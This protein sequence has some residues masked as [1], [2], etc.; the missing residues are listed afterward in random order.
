MIRAMIFDLDGTLVQTEK[1]KARSY[2]KAIVELCPYT[3]PEDEATEAFKEFVGLSRKEVA[4]GLIERYDLEE[5]AV[6][7]LDQMGVETTWQAFV[8]IRL[9]YYEEMMRDPNIIRDNQWSHNMDLLYIARQQNCKTALATMSQREQANRVLDILNIH[10][11]FDFIATRDDV[12][13][14][15]P[16]P[17]IY[18]LVSSELDIPPDET[19][20]IED[21]PSGV[22]AAIAAGMQVVAVSTP[23]TKAH[24]HQLDIL[25]ESHIVDEPETLLKVVREF[26]EI[27]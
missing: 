24:L 26:V 5:K 6:K 16:N 22:K 23:F 8:Q 18:Q 21:S 1:L 13:H 4:L 12:E 25:D 10:D 3:V 20:V 7:R 2:A 17:E 11:Q 14:S 15:K 19:L 27:P 9:K